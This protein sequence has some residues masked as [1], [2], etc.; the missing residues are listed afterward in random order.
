MANLTTH[1]I[2]IS[3]PNPFW[4]ASAPPTD[5]A[6][7]VNR[8]FEAGWG[9]VVWKTL[10]EEGPPIVN[11]NGPRYGALLTPDR[12]LTGFNNIEL[13]TD[14]DLALNLKEITEVKRLWPD[15]AMVV[16]LMVPCNEDAWRAILP[17]VEDTGCDGIELNFG[18]P[19]G[20]SERGMGAAVGQV[21]EYIQMV[22]HW[23]KQ[24]SRLPVIVKLT[25]NITDIRL[26]ARA[27]KHGGADAVS[28]INTINS[29]M[30]V[31]PYSLTMEPSTGGKG[32]HGGYCGP[33]VKPIALNMVAEIARDPQT[34]GLPIS[35]IGG[36]TTWRDAFDYIALGAGNVQVCTAAMVYGFKIVQEMTDGLSNYMDEMGFT[37]IEDFRG[38]AIP[39][40]SDWKYLNLNHISKA[41]INQDTCIECGRC[42]I[43]CE[44][45]SHQA[46]TFEKDGKRHFEVKEDECVGCNLCTLVC[47]VPDC[48]TL[49]TLAPGETDLRTGKTVLASHADW[50]TH[51]N[52]PGRV[53]A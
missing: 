17:R 7:N 14:R 33:A 45:T 40:V 48:I 3:S 28:L 6:T 1:F 16:S 37:S 22:T 32:S 11:V 27:A 15:R 18:C 38:K 4:L 24:Y 44:D 50:T 41:V 20:M 51:A 31:D 47:P 13:I 25:P 36:V 53:A 8:A 21:P 12:R 35:G 30:G 49:R 39:S 29:I 2:G 52:N 19:H 34:A 10:G 5:K 23:C 43:A 46:I 42:H 9:G 26:P